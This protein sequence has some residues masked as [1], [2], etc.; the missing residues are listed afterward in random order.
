MLTSICLETVQNLSK[1]Q[2]FS[3][4]D[5]NVQWVKWKIE[6]VYRQ[7]FTFDDINTGCPQKSAPEDSENGVGSED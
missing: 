4:L 3:E 2:T 5:D 7:T 6:V 1:N